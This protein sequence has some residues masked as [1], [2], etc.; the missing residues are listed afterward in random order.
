MKT[1]FFGDVCARNATRKLFE[2]C[3]KN[4]LFGNI[5]PLFGNSDF[6][7]VNLECALTDSDREIEK[8]G[9][10][11]KS[12]LCTAELLR[13]I[14]VHACG[15][16]N[17]HIFDYGKK[18]IEDTLDA[19]SCAKLLYTGFGMNETDARKN[20]YFEKDGEK[21][22]IIAVCE[23]EYNYALPDRMGSRVYDCY[24]TIE[25]IQAAKAQADRVIVLYHGGKE[26]CRYPS[27]RLRKLCRAMAKNGA[28]LILCQHSHCIGCYEEFEGCHIL[29]GQGNFHFVHDRIPQE[30]S[31]EMWNT[32]LAVRYDTASGAVEWIPVKVDLSTNG[33]CLLEG[34][35]KNELLNAFE[36]RNR[37][38]QSDAWLDGWRAFCESIRIPYTK[39]AY[40]SK[41]TDRDKE[42]FAHFLDCEAHTDVWRELFYTKNLTNEK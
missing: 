15:L 33:V 9:P 42:K 29:Y 26:H 23:R 40:Q 39:V 13:E 20:L 32:S 21:I 4:A 3:D 34:A 37:E 8:M 31:E 10:A 30:S 7:M 27:P 1:L 16:S 18:G 19:L 5:L 11:L 2:A 24:D 38:L 41:E 14:G 35:K 25:D 28:D 17:N 6:N 36:E 12:P 22:A